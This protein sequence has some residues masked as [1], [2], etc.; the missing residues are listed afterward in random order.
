MITGID[1]EEVASPPEPIDDWGVNYWRVECQ[2][3]FDPSEEINIKR[4]D[5]MRGFNDGCA[6]TRRRLKKAVQ[7]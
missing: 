4:T 6:F 1:I 3:P 7:P 5:Y 2:L